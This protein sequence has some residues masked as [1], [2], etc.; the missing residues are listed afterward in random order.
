VSGR[1]R[2]VHLGETG[3]NAVRPTPVPKASSPWGQNARRPHQ[4]HFRLGGGGDDSRYRT[5]R[6]CRGFGLRSM[7]I[8]GEERAGDFEDFGDVYR[9]H[10]AEVHAFIRS[11]VPDPDDVEDL[12]LE[13]FISAY[14]AWNVYKV[15][16]FTPLLEWLLS[17]A[18]FNCDKHLRRKRS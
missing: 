4:G 3:T 17:V 5:R 18:N 12:T 2:A 15:R 14:R 10:Y 1:R 7:D 11:R 13:V 9:A 16:C 8:F 6:A